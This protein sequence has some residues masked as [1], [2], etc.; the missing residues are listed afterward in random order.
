MPDARPDYGL[1]APPVVRRLA[2]G[3]FLG[4][5][6]AFV[7]IRSGWKGPLIWT[8]AG[9]SAWWLVSAVIMVWGSRVGKLRLRTRI[10][11]GIPWRGDE[12]VLDIGCGRGL[13]TVGV[14]DRIPHGRAVGIDVWRAEDQTDNRPAATREN[15]RRGG[16]TARVSLVTADARHLPFRAGAFDAV[17][18][19]FALHNIAGR[20]DRAAAVEEAW[21]VAREGG[22]VIILDVRHTRQYAQVLRRRGAEDV[23]R[24]AP[25]F[26]FV[27]PSFILTA[28]K[29]RRDG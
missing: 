29:S 6:L 4:G 5:V 11:E 28:G 8:L 17:V 16:V 7:A 26:G 20:Q 25:H 18:S 2:L 24:S 22:R 3:G 15:L 21:R 14:A 13:L 10:L 23:R 9:V 1:D 19:S 12:R 27:I